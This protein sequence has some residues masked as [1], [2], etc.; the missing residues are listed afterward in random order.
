M[1]NI[2]S[3]FAIFLLLSCSKNFNKENIKSASSFQVAKV[4]GKHS[5]FISKKKL[6]IKQ[7]SSS[8]DCESWSV[9]LDLDSPLRKS[10]NNLIDSMFTDYQMTE[11]KLSISEIEKNGY[12]SQISFF[13][14]NAYSNF[15]TKRNTGLYD[16]NLILK[17]KVENSNEN[18]ITEIS[19]NMNWEK[20][21]F[22]NCNL[23]EGAVKSGQNALNNLLKKIYESTYESIYKI[24][25]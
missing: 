20:N 21:I 13:D 1:K 10:I 19:S 11:E 2:L 7:T 14:F 24:T 17:M 3:I 25:R 5:I 16:I 6:N 18:I 4:E 12:V 8:E 23:H 15:K 22:L 9:K